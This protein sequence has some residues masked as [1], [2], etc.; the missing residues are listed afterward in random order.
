MSAGI[1]TPFSWRDRDPFGPDIVR[2]N[3]GVMHRARCADGTVRL[4]PRCSGGRPSVGELITAEE[5]RRWAT[6]REWT[7]CRYPWCFREVVRAVGV[8]PQVGHVARAV[9]RAGLRPDRRL[10][11]DRVAPHVPTPT[12]MHDFVDGWAWCSCDRILSRATRA[13]NPARTWWRHK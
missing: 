3:R 6:G 9:S 12:R 2:S 7:L 4:H 1:A 11:E 10:H 5:A 8:D 13:H